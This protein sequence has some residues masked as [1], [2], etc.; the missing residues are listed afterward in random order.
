MVPKEGAR[1]NGG[2]ERRR[3][4]HEG[5]G[6]WWSVA[7]AG[8]RNMVG[9]EEPRTETRIRAVNEAHACRAEAESA[10]P[11]GSRSAQVAFAGRQD[12]GL[13]GRWQL[14]TA[15]RAEPW[16]RGHGG[17]PAGHTAWLGGRGARGCRPAAPR[18]WEECQASKATATLAAERARQQRRMAPLQGDRAPQPISAPPVAAGAD[19]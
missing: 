6:G 16:A 1:C 5:G 17:W 19:I 3:T 13:S 11:G 9:W 18:P 14:G 10:L 8:G 12:A 7:S 15:G 4:G 2:G